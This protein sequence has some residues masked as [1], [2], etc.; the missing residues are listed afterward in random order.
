[1]ICL[2]SSFMIDIM[3]KKEHAVNLFSAIKEDVHFTTIINVYELMS[4][5]YQIRDRNY[6]RHI[7]ILEDFHSTMHI[8]DL[9]KAS[10][11][12]ASKLSG[13][14]AKNGAIIEDLDILIAG[15]CLS[16]GCSRIATKN[17]KHFDRINGLK[18]ETY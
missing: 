8:L 10:T 18:V 3:R 16:N 11:A 12:Q 15:I 2:D 7:K 1:M 5:I 4:G 14:L 17:K 13:E 9:D 6:E